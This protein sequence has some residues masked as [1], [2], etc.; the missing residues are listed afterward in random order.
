MTADNPSWVKV[1]DA[2]GEGHFV[3]QTT[4]AGHTLP[5]IRVPAIKGVSRMGINNHLKESLEAG[6][7]FAVAR[8]GTRGMGLIKVSRAKIE[9]TS[10]KAPVNFRPADA[11]DV[12]HL[13]VNGALE[14]IG[15]DNKGQ[16]VKIVFAHRKSSL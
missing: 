11:Y 15:V 2:I 4:V 9:V 12:L 5:E 16:A 6:L 7:S 14:I 3:V 10:I 1:E 8:A 13:D